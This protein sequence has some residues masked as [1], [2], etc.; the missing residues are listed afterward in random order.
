MADV[1]KDTPEINTELEL[2][3]GLS[4]Q[5]ESAEEKKTPESDLGKIFKS[6]FL[7]T[8]GG[9]SDIPLYIN[10]SVFGICEPSIFEFSKIPCVTLRIFCS[11]WMESFKHI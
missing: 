5:P 9:I 3:D 11:A 10:Q 1:K 6:N 8:V 4:E 7:R 2:E